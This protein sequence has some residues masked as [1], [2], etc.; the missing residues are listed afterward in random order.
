MP[1]AEY[2]NMVKAFPPDRTDQPFS[3]FQ[4]ND[5]VRPQSAWFFP[6]AD[7]HALWLSKYSAKLIQTSAVF[8]GEERGCQSIDCSPGA[9]YCPLKLRI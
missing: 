6:D 9:M 3:I 1:L 4:A 8:P 2:N 5:A 7:E